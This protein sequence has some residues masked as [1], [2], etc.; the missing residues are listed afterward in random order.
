MDIGDIDL[1]EVADNGVMFTL[2]HPITRA[3]TDIKIKIHGSDSKIYRDAQRANQNKRI[4][5]MQKNRN[6]HMTADEIEIEALNMLAL[7][8]TGWE[9]MEK[10]GK[11]VPFSPENAKLIYKENPWIR[12]QIEEAIGDRSNFTKK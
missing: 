1:M 6:F 12:E 8:T 7:C 5:G 4:K 10:D 9:N 3:E 2:L 11:K